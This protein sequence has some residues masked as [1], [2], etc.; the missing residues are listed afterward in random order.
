MLSPP[1]DVSHVPM[2]HQF[3]GLLIDRDVSLTHL[4]GVLDHFA[5]FLVWPRDALRPFR[6]FHRAEFRGGYFLRHLRRQ[7]RAG[8]GPS[9]GCAR[10]DGSSLEGGMLHRT[11]SKL[12]GWIGRNGRLAFGW[13]VER[14]MMMSPGDA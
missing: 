10:K 12:A 4:K 13:G 5:Q 8:P 6:T 14:T 7:G 1:V 2:F 3:E 9:A 11:S